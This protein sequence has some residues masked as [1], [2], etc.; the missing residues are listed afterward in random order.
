MPATNKWSIRV[1]E[2]K[3]YVFVNDIRHSKGGKDY[4]NI[5]RAETGEF[6]KHMAIKVRLRTF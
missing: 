2:D 5:L 6:K 4:S 1:S 3:A